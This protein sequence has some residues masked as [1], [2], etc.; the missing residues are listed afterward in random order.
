MSVV[1]PNRIR[2]WRIAKG[3]SLVTLSSQIGTTPDALSQIERG[4]RRLHVWRMTYIAKALKI[5]VA[6]LLPWEQNPQ[7]LTPPEWEFLQLWRKISSENK[8]VLEELML[9]PVIH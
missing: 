5:P 9:H 2:E 6:Q 4:H 3:M 1:L 8:A 7:S